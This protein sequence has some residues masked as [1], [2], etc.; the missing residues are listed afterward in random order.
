[1]SVILDSTL[2]IQ[3]FVRGFPKLK[4]NWTNDGELLDT[5]NM[6]TINRMTYDDAGRYKCSAKNS[7][8]KNEAA[9]HNTVTG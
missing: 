9:F 8:G 2:Q 5:R 1:M 7:K 6:L 4:V 3:S